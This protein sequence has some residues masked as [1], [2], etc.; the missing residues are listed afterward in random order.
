M[1]GDSAGG[2]AAGWPKPPT[3]G[4]IEKVGVA[5][6]CMGMLPTFRPCP[7]M[8]LLDGFAAAVD[9]PPS[10]NPPNPVTFALLDQDPLLVALQVWAEGPRSTKGEV[11][12]GLRGLSRIGRCI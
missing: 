5:G 9:W 7:K 3:V 1:A 11:V 12:R 8:E 2:N 10:P 4:A 6:V